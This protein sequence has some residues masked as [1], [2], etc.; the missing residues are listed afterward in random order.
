MRLFNDK[1]CLPPPI[2]KKIKGVI[3]VCDF[4]NY[5]LLFKMEDNIFEKNITDPLKIESCEQRTLSERDNAEIQEKE[6]KLPFSNG[7][8]TSM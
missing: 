2:Q 1:F 8:S 5:F 7:G 3:C 6:K 4:T